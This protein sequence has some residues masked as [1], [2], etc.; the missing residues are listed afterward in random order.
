METR[1]INRKKL[2][3][4]HPAL[5]PYRIDFFNA[6]NEAFDLK[7]F[8][9][10]KNVPNQ[11]FN[12]ENLLRS[13]NFT[14]YYLHNG[15]DYN[16]RPFRFGISKIIKDYKPDIIICSEYSQI[17]VA[18]FVLHKLLRLKFRL[19]TISDDSIDN[20]KNRRGIRAWLRN[21]ISKNIDGI[22]FTSEEVAKW[23]KKNIS[24][25]INALELPI[26]HNDIK[27]RN[28]LFEALP[29][30]Q[31]NIEKYDLFGKRI[32]LYVGRLS[33]EKNIHLLINAFSKLTEEDLRLIIVGN[34]N[35]SNDLQNF[36][37]T[38]N[39][40]SK[41]IFTGR[42]E[43]YD[44]YSWYTFPQIFVLPS[45]YEPY[46]AVVNEALL[47]GCFVVC[48]KLAGAASLINF[49]NGRLFNPYDENDLV[50]KLKNILT[51]VSLLEPFENIRES[52]MPFTFED[53]IGKLI[54]K[55]NI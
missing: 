36:A 18:V 5:A 48:S 23:N 28:K 47:G 3:V 10:Y 51:N 21:I 30:A 41:V 12:Q 1:T 20:S 15:F 13:L 33:K 25:K 6:L 34:G 24:N 8:L 26:I 32:I 31:K 52:K 16:N 53:K 2:L 43:S 27:F 44:L 11:K 40:Q 50:C 29:L 37:A 49:N 19:Y 22:L 4:F 54:R 7:L 17:T 38:L 9:C 46:G 14:P 42:L 35:L 45:I 55:L 39:I